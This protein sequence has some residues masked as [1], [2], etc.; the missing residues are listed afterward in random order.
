MVCLHAC[1]H[2]CVCVSAFLV[3]NRPDDLLQKLG[4]KS[5]VVACKN[6]MMSLLWRCWMVWIHGGGRVVKNWPWGSDSHTNT[7]VA[8]LH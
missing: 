6:T 4:S 7:V 3:G 8:R 5:P 2:A 1:M